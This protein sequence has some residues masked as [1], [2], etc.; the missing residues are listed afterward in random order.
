MGYSMFDH[1]IKVEPGKM[2]PH[3]EDESNV[4]LAEKLGFTV[5]RSSQYERGIGFKKGRINIWQF[6]RGWQVADLYRHDDDPEFDYYQNHRPVGDL[7][8]ALLREAYRA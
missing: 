1:R 8:Y 4:K 6:R 2:H 3:R 7:K 5:D